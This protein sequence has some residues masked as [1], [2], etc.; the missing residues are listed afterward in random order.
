MKTR[1]NYRKVSPGGFRA[2]LGLEQYVANCGL[3][4]SI[5]E[6]VKLRASQINH[7][8]FCIDMHWKD[9]RAAGESEQRLY[10]LPAW[11]ECPWYSDR[12]RAALAWTEAVTKLTEGFVPD[13]VYE[14]VRPNFDDKELADLTWLIAAINS[15]NRVNVALRGETGTYQPAAGVN[16][17]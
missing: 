1:I 4:K 16:A 3:E 2:M 12:E 17:G 9:A 10:S 11:R 14:E 6:F 8:A 13:E 5:I 7:C 15:W